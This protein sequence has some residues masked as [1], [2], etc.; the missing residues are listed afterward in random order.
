MFEKLRLITSSTWS[1][2]R[3]LIVIFLSKVG[4]VLA[5]AAS[6]AVAAQAQ[7]AASGYEKR[8]GA[9]NQIESSLVSQGIA[10]GTD[11]TASMINAAIEVAVLKLKA[12]G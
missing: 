3:P 9:F 12:E 4:P 10:V 11:V 5:K 7:R 8:A 1:F 6:A 2:L